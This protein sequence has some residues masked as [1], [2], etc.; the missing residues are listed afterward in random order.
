MWLS[1]GSSYAFSTLT[2]E[3][4]DPPV[5]DLGNELANYEHLQHL[6]LSKN[7]I[8]EISSIGSLPELVT[9]N[10]STNAVADI[11]FLLELKGSDRLAFLQVS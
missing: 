3:E 11:R 1:D 4:S 10:C 7:A 9:V 2:M 6:H 5:T 8:K